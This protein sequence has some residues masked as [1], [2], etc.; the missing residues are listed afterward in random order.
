MKKLI[1]QITLMKDPGYVNSAFDDDR[2]MVKLSV[3][4]STWDVLKCPLLDLISQS[5]LSLLPTIWALLL[6]SSRDDLNCHYFDDDGDDL[7]IDPPCHLV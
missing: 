7:G 2:V 6:S 1:H 3:P 5:S 4:T